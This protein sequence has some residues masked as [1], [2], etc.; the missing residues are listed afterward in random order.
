MNIHDEARRLGVTFYV[1][2]N[3]EWEYYKNIYDVLAYDDTP[4]LRHMIQSC[5]NMYQLR[6][7]GYKNETN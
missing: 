3:E 7:S 5:I 2:T 1:M 6:E 4:N